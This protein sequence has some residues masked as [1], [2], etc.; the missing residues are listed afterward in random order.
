M[1][2]PLQRV[3]DE[4]GLSQAELARALGVPG[5]QVS[6]IIA[7]QSGRIPAAFGDR[8]AELGVQPEP[9]CREYEE[10][11]RDRGSAHREAVVAALKRGNA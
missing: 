3:M 9:I 2:N 7:G 4:L 1:E 8:L 11:L 10:W 6:N 5:I